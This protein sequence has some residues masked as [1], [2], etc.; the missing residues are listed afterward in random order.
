MGL[1]VESELLDCL[2]R[3]HGKKNVIITCGVLLKLFIYKVFSNLTH[4]L[5]RKDT[6]FFADMQIF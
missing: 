5:T 3:E 4:N 1:Q 6:T 2:R